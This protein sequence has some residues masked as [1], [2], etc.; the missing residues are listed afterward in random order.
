MSASTT[1]LHQDAAVPAVT[2]AT[3]DPFILE[4][5]VVRGPGFCCTAYRDDAGKWH[6]AFSNEELFGEIQVV[7]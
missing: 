1:I 7:E 2:P 3:A 5:F 6:E 4:F